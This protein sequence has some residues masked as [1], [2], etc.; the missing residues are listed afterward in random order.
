MALPDTWDE[1]AMVSLYRQGDTTTGEVQFMSITEEIEVNEGDYPYETIPNTA[2]GRIGK[3]SPQEDGEIT[4]K[5]REV[6]LTTSSGDTI[7]R[8]GM[9]QFWNGVSGAIPAAYDTSEPLGTD[10]SWPAGITRVRDTFR[11]SI[12][13]TNDPAATSAAGA[14][15]VSTD[16]RRVYA[17]GC[18]IT[19]YGE[20]FTPED[21]WTS[22]VTFKFGAMNKAGTVKNCVRESGD[23]TALVTLGAYS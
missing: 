9:A 12:L 14:T 20:K 2:G 19:H 21:G 13:T 23:Q 1:V 18:K 15:A 22:E 10:S 4:L 7:P 8:P 6:E 16:A 11:V 17:T 3:Q 5:L